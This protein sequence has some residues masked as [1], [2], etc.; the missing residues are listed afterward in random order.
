ME[1]ESFED[2]HVA[3][4][5]NKG[6]VCIKVDREERPDLDDIY[7][8]ATLAMNKG[9]GGWPMTV[10][11]TPDQKPF[12][13]GTY[14]PPVDRYG[15]PGFSSILMKITEMWKTKREELLQQGQKLTEHLLSQSG[16]IAAQKSGTAEIEAAVTQL[17]REFDP[18]QGGFGSAPKFPP[19]TALSLLL[20]H[21]RRTGDSFSLNIV[22]VTLDAM[23]RGG[24]YDQIGGGFARYST[25]DRWLVP[26]FEKMLY[27]NALISKVYIEAYQVTGAPLYRRIATETLDYILREMT[28][29][30]GGFFSATDADSEGVEGQFFVWT[31]SEIQKIL[32]EE[33]MRWFCAYYDITEQGNWEGK[34]IPNTPRPLSQI[35]ERLSVPEE[36]LAASLDLS[37]KKLYEERLK[38]IPPGLDD[39]I[40]TAWNGLMIG[41]MAEGARILGNNH[42]LKAAEKAADFLLKT[43]SQSDGRL[44][45]TYRAGKAHLNAYLEDYAYFCEGLIDLYEAGSD[46]R[47]LKEATRLAEMIVS[48]FSPEGDGGFYSTSRTHETLLLRPREGYDGALPNANASAA[49]ALIRLSYHLGREDLRKAG[50]RSI[51]GYGKVIQRAPRAFCKSLAVIDFL[52]KGPIEL[53]IVG[54]L[55]HPETQALRAEFDK[56]YLP[57]RI[58]AHKDP[59]QPAEENGFSHPLL[60]GKDLVNGKPAVY[61]CEN[62]VCQA[63][64]TD[65]KAVGKALDDQPLKIDPSSGKTS[66]PNRA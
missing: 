59:T 12:F 53:A 32:P 64:L 14:F 1:R 8:A 15:R 28:S 60:Q 18:A 45:R 52:S 34:N 56:R 50:I 22:Q 51:E 57:N 20:R 6:F 11:L 49:S 61:I 16:T 63:P 9:Q 19:A 31:P 3:G 47:Y 36:K 42:Y 13:A 44:W 40:L 26:H 10:F 24:I 55:H 37:R 43:L 5:M 25:D 66:K 54:K 48:D 33:E 65:P 58:M 62:F 35:A 30:E 2:S 27:D 29:P 38:R 21:H 41:S 39:K 7:M 4:I 46:Q 17:S 23:A